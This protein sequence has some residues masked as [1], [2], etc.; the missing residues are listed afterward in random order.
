MSNQRYL[1][2]IKENISKILPSTELGEIN[3]STELEAMGLNSIDRV[4]LIVMTLESLKI[5]YSPSDIET[6]STIGQLFAFLA[7]V[8][9]KGKKAS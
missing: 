3:D 1:S 2:L 8:E 9:S 5:N 6:P 7:K 4:D